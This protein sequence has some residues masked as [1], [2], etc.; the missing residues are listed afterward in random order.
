M[1]CSYVRRITDLYYA[2]GTF[3]LLERSGYRLVDDY[4]I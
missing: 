1:S 3:V 2:Y 4:A